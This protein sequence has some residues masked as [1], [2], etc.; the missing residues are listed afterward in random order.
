M[1]WLRLAWAMVG[2]VSVSTTWCQEPSGAAWGPQTGSVDWSLKDDGLVW[3]TPLLDLRL[4]PWFTLRHL[5]GTA[6]QGSGASSPENALWDNLRGAHFDATLDGLWQ[7]HGSLEE[8]QGV[9]GA[10]DAAAMPSHTA[11]PGWGRAKPLDNGRV[12]VARSRVTAKYIRPLSLRDSLTVTSAYAPAG[13]GAFPSSLTL[14]QDAASYPHVS[15]G[16]TRSQS[17]RINLTA[18]RWTSDERGP[19]GGSTESLFRPSDAGWADFTWM[20]SRNFTVGALAGT[21]RE[22]S[23]TQEQLADSSDRFT[24][25]P[26][27]SLTSSWRLPIDGVSISGEWASHQGWGVGAIWHKPQRTRLAWTTMRLQDNPEATLWTHAATPVSSVLRA[28]GVSGD[29]WRTEL[30]GQWQRN[31]FMATSRAAVVGEFAVWEASV[32]WLLQGTW[33]LYASLGVELWDGGAGALLPEQG[34]RIRLGV[35]HQM[36]M[37]PGSTTFAAP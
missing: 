27:F 28:A 9:P 1:T 33:P 16:V 8:M 26:W 23:W 4:N 13:W 19:D 34:R 10:W 36:G 30:R 20:S 32:G 12:D 31:R 14:S 35:S 15:V 3:R 2:F 24:W 11:L 6:P 17:W 7:I 18:A 22:R 37:T 29:V 21:V 25:T 5:S